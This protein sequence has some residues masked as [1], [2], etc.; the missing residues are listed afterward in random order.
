[1][2]GRGKLKMK[3]WK[4]VGAKIELFGQKDVLLC[5]FF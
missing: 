5:R 1:M 2:E 3:G 4:N